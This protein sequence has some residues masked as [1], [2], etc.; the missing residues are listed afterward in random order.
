[1]GEWRSFI[2][3]LCTSQIYYYVKEKGENNMR[4]R[5]F[6]LKDFEKLY[7][8]VKQD[9]CAYGYSQIEEVKHILS[10]DLRGYRTLGKCKKNKVNASVATI[11]LNKAYA[12]STTIQKIKNTIMHELI[13]SIKGCLGHTGKWK[14]IA[15][16]VTY[17][18]QR[19]YEIERLTITCLEFKDTA[20]REQGPKAMGK[21]IVTCDTCGNTW[22]Y[23]KRTKVIQAIERNKGKGYKCPKCK[24]SCFS[25]KNL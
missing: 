12:D 21:Y 9:L 13:H 25:L 22:K 5:D 15:Q 17:K 20:Q 4:I 14:D 19:K 18:S 3:F 10:L 24:G 8:E 23:Q 16:M 6:T 1:M 7:K 11:Y 2:L